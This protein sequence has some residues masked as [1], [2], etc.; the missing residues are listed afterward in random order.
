MKEQLDTLSPQLK[1]A[2]AR[3]WNGDESA[4]ALAREAFALAINSGGIKELDFERADGV[5]FNPWPARIALIVLND[6]GET[7]PLA[8]LTAVLLPVLLCGGNFAPFT[9]PGAAILEQAA[10]AA[11]LAAEAPE[12]TLAAL[13]RGGDPIA[14]VAAISQCAQ[15]LDRI[16]HLHQADKGRLR[17]VLPEVLASGE[18]V[19][20]VASRVAPAIGARI[21]HWRM[22]VAPRLLALVQRPE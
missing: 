2:L 22:R 13:D 12:A 19:L 5:S 6:A 15:H 17:E 8:V 4:L 3:E 20:K 7:S 9:M 11:N 21:K 1:G 14:R 16:R 10:A 18:I